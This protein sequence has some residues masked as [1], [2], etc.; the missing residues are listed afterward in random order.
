MTATLTPRPAT[1]AQPTTSWQQRPAPP[2]AADTPHDLRT[3]RLLGGVWPMARPQP[4]EE[5]P[6][7][8]LSPGASMT[9]AA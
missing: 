8:Q 3:A 1:S 5:H 6:L 2:A 9:A 7:P 4:M